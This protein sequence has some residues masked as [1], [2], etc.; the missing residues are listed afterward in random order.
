M[1]SVILKYPL[2]LT[3]KNA[4]NLVTGEVHVLNTGVNRAFVP[5]YGPFFTKS[6][7]VREASTNKLLTANVHYKA[8]QLEPTATAD[9]GL[10][11]CCIIVITDT[12]ISS[13][14]IIDYQVVGGDYSAS[15][16]ALQQMI[17]ALN[18]DNR[19]VAWGDV[20]GKPSEYVPAEHRHDAG[21]LYG[22]EYLVAAIE[23]LRQAI[24][25]GDDASHDAIYKYV[26][27][28]N[29]A[30]DTAVATNKQTMDTH[31]ANT[32]NPHQTTKSQ[33]GLGNVLNYGIAT[34]ADAQAGTSNTLY[35]TPLRVKEAISKIA[36]D[37]L[38]GHLT[39]KNNP[40]AVTK[41][42]VELGNVQNFG[43]ATDTEAQIGSATNKYMTPYAVKLALGSISANNAIHF[44]NKTYAEV[45]AA[46]AA[47]TSANSTKFNGYT[48]AEVATAWQSD[49]A[50]VAANYIPL[51]RL[52]A[53]NVNG[54]WTP[55][56]SWATIVGKA[57]LISAGGIMEVGKYIDFHDTNSIADYDVRLMAIANQLK[58]IGNLSWS[59]KAYGDGSG[60]TNI[61]ASKLGGRDDSAYAL[62]SDLVALQG[63]MQLFRGAEGASVVYYKVAELDTSI[64]T[65]A[66]DFTAIISG[67]E[68]YGSTY[69]ASAIVRI[70]TRSTGAN[71][72]ATLLC[73]KLGASTSEIGFVKTAGGKTE[74]W[75]KS[76][77][78][79][80][81]LTATI[82]NNL[83]ASTVT[84]TSTTM[85]TGYT[86]IT[87]DRYYKASE[88][89]AAALDSTT[90]AGKSVAQLT[91]DILAGTAA[92]ADKLGG[93]TLTTIMSDV[94]ASKVADTNKFDGKLYADM[95]KDILDETIAN[96]TKFDGKTYAEAKS[97]ITAAAA[98]AA[99]ATYVPK[100]DIVVGGR[101]EDIVNKIPRVHGSGY[102]EIGNRLNF[103]LP[104]ASSGGDPDIYIIANR[105]S[106]AT[107]TSP[108]IN[109][110][111]INGNIRLS[112]GHKFS[113]DGSGL[114]AVNAAMLGS[115]TYT[116]VYDDFTARHDGR[117]LKLTDVNANNSLYANAIGK[118]PKI[119]G[120]GVMEVARIIDYKVLNSAVTDFDIRSL[121]QVHGYTN[122]DYVNGVNTAVAKETKELHTTRMATSFLRVE[123]GVGIDYGNRTNQIYFNG[124]D[125]ADLGGS[126]NVNVRTWYGFSVSSACIDMPATFNKVAFSVNARTGDIRWWGVAYG[127]GSQI[128]NVNAQTLD[129]I[130]SSGFERVHTVI[131]KTIGSRIYRHAN[132]WNE[133]G[134]DPQDGQAYIVRVSWS[135]SGTNGYWSYYNGAFIFACVGGNGN[136][137]F[138][139]FSGEV[140]GAGAYGERAS[141]RVAR[142]TGLQ[143]CVLGGGVNKN[144]SHDKWV[145]MTLNVDIKPIF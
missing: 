76:T 37:S 5:S 4:N 1:I 80:N 78:H 10:E 66:N 16:Y 50:T 118:V 63:S 134:F 7:I 3:G 117:Y 127:D 104:A 121:C 52:N 123:S 101:F 97:D 26:D 126:N 27:L 15:V 140:N 130:D 114:S 112:A 12:S 95:K 108:Q 58:V 83:N 94:A 119:G 21:D 40:H 31:I 113:G 60:I 35:M 84:T 96:S 102:F 20:I 111:Y 54:V 81:K 116:G 22:F 61:D 49:A 29:G 42:Q 110:F 25:I 98:T 53:S 70:G 122:I 99:T 115:K 100:S 64:S 105:V 44:N 138:Q 32:A 33:V 28:K 89:V 75:V 73:G 55:Q 132:E 93:K 120:D 65:G 11:V 41:S 109:E 106:E 131:K 69:G 92:N 103:H 59:G 45:L 34:T 124:G 136:E 135:V 17:D 48:Y 137:Y 23:E 51:S 79:R 6:L 24:I 141:W 62:K 72:E 14:V 129:G 56:S 145:G 139:T 46:A 125:R 143:I 2:D 68:N 19:A 36:G 128:K 74:L 47:Q 9:S 18:L 39:D 38:T 142:N 85:P 71:V 90:L 87:M 67:L 82:L 57:P 43:I 8:I 86:A 77:S 13:R 30:Q 91:T 133:T 144:L 107:G 88:T